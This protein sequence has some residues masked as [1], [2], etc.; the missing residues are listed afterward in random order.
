MPEA[1]KIDKI[2]MQVTLV[3]EEGPDLFDELAAIADGK[4]RGARLKGL[5]RIGLAAEWE[6]RLGNGDRGGRLARPQPAD[7][8]GA[9]PAGEPRMAAS[10]LNWGDDK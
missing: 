4:R 8:G 10:L 6:R 2:V 7:G 3:E 5:A 9:Q 1:D